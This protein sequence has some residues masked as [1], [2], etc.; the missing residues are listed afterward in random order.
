MITQLQALRSGSADMDAISNTLQQSLKLLRCLSQLHHK[1]QQ[2][3]K[4]PS[5]NR[6]KALACSK[7]TWVFLAWAGTDA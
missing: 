7:A 6:H 4:P 1:L 5:L 2:S 3:S